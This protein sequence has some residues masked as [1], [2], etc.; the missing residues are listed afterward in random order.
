ML[1]QDRNFLT[2][3]L[4]SIVTCGIYELYYL[5]EIARDTNQMCQGDGEETAGLG[6]YILL[7]IVTCGIYAYYWFYKLGD[8]LHKNAPRYNLN[9][10]ETG[11]TILLYLLINLLSGGIGTIIATYFIN[12]NINA[13]AAAYNQWISGNGQTTQYPQI[14]N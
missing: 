14:N 1:K 8:R 2:I 6:M 9:F 5:Y 10:S 3:V 11:S 12:R 13:M 4:L 7:S